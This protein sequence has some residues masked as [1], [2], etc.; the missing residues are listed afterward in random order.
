MLKNI[1]EYLLTQHFYQILRGR[2]TNEQGSQLKFN[3]V[4]AYLLVGLICRLGRCFDFMNN[5]KYIFL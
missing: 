3:A 4:C 5:R 1:C 2:H